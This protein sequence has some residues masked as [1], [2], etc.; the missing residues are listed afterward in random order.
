MID[1]ELYKTFSQEQVK[2]FYDD[3]KAEVGKYEAI[4]SSAVETLFGFIDFDKFKQAILKHKSDLSKAQAT[5][6]TAK[7]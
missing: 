6:S 1:Q 3:F 7:G 5:E 4:N 2:A